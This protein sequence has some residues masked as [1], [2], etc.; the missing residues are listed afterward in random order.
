LGGR[1]PVDGDD[2]PLARLG[3]SE[4]SGKIGAQIAHAE[5]RSAGG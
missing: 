5:V 3:S 2:H 4:V 1:T